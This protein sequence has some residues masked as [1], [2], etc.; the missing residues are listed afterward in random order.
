MQA[1]RD[2]TGTPQPSP[3]LD[4]KASRLQEYVYRAAILVAVI[5][6]LWTVA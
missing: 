2:A 4:P 6:L 1:T 5:L 3:T